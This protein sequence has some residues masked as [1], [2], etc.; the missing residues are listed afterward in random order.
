MSESVNAKVQWIKK[1]ACGFRNRERFRTAIMFHCG[2]LDMEPLLAHT[3][4]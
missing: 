1:N 3:N 4:A 2:G